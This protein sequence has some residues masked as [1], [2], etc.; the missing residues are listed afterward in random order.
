MHKFIFVLE[1]GWSFF[2]DSTFDK[3][4]TGKQSNT[5]LPYRCKHIRTNTFDTRLRRLFVYKQEILSLHWCT[6][7][8]V[9]RRTADGHGEC[10]RI[11][12]L[13]FLPAQRHRRASHLASK[14]VLKSFIT[15]YYAPRGQRSSRHLEQPYPGGCLWF[16]GLSTRIV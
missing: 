3:K 14:E 9:L 6:V 16:F 4:C 15:F 13:H 2:T 11:A 1:K 12:T 8:Q 7:G 5:S 10:E